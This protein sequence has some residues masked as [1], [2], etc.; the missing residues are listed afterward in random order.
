VAPDEYD[1]YLKRAYHAAKFVKPRNFVG[2]EKSLP[3][4]E[5]KK[6]LITN[7]EVTDQDLTKLAGARANAVRQA[8]VKTIDPSRLFVIAPRLNPD[9]IKDKGK[10]TRADLSLE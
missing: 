10:T 1:K 6:L 2:L 7:T 4:D 9:G 5:M 8:L 3:S